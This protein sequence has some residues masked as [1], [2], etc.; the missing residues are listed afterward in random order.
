M[1]VKANGPPP[2]PEQSGIPSKS[3][4]NTRQKNVWSTIDQTLFWQD[5]TGLYKPYPGRLAVCYLYR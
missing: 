2:Q 5:A 1:V 3:M 4:E